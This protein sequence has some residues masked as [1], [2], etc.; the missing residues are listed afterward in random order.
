MSVAGNTQTSSSRFSGRIEILSSVD[1]ES[2]LGQLNFSIFFF[3]LNLAIR[4]TFLRI[5]DGLSSLTLNMIAAGRYSLP[6]Q[7]KHS[8]VSGIGRLEINVK[9]SQVLDWI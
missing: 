1:I 2:N 4:F 7:A 3:S 5:F 6:R 9:S 8:S